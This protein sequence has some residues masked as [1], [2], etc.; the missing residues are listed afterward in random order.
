MVQEIDNVG[1]IICPSC[2]KIY[3]H[4]TNY[5]GKICV[6]CKDWIPATKEL[7]FVKLNRLKKEALKNK[8]LKQ[9]KKNLGLVS[10]IDIIKDEE[11]NY[12]D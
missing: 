6:V 3:H 1:D 11:V 10:P 8:A 9:V 2:G 12:G 5:F 7:E 4:Y